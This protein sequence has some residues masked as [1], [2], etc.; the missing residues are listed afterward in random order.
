MIRS[1]ENITALFPDSLKRAQAAADSVL[2]TRVASIRA[3]PAPELIFHYTND[4]GLHGI[5]SSGKIWLTDVV[6]L[7]D[8][9]ELQHGVD[10]AFEELHGAVNPKVELEVQF[11]TDFQAALT[12]RATAISQNFVCCFSTAGNELS[13][14]RAYADNARGFA[15]GFGGAELETAFCDI[16]D[17]IGRQTFSMSYSDQNL[18]NLHRKLI[19][20]VLPEVLAPLRQRFPVKGFEEQYMRYLRELA[21]ILAG[22][23]LL[24]STH[25]KHSA[26]ATESEYRFHEMIAARKEVPDVRQRARHNSVIRYREFDWRQF[27]P[28]SLKSIMV[29]PASDASRAVEFAKGILEKNGYG[30]IQPEVS[31]IPYRAV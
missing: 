2:E 4:V 29:G 18:R 1:I 21:V 8:P 28:N 12:N 20:A 24:A 7:N 19:D 30:N 26:Y 14:W 27:A 5:L 15:I 13:Q 3:D 9:S 6:G 11:A 10:L 16:N 31:K 25:F 22:S 23:I 17:G